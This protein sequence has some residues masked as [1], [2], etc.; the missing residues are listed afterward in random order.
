MG[1]NLGI[2]YRF[3]KYPRF[4]LVFLYFLLYNL[5]IFRSDFE[6]DFLKINSKQR[7][8]SMARSE[9][10]IQSFMLTRSLE[11]TLNW[12]DKEL[13]F[14]EEGNIQKSRSDYETILLR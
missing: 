3:F 6:K 5:T 14:I 4:L 11:R 1:D 9:A 7:G 12:S 10:P 2:I 8:L 13:K